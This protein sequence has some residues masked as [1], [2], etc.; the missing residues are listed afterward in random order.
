LNKS[1]LILLI[2]LSQILCAQISPG[3]LTKAHAKLEGISNCTNCHEIGQRVKNSKCLNCHTEVNELISQSKGYHSNSEVTTKNCADC[4]S[5]HHGRNFRIVNFIP[6]NFEHKKTTFPLTGKHIQLKCS[7]CHN[8]KNIVMPQAIKMNSNWMGLSSDCS[9]CHIDYHQGTLGGSCAGCH[10]TTNFRPSEFDHNKAAFVL[11][12][13]HLKTPCI[14]CHPKVIREGKE[15]QRFSDIKFVSCENC[16]KDVHGGRLGKDCKSCHNTNS[17]RSIK[18]NTFDHSKTGF[19]LLGKHISVNCNSCHKNSL[20]E[21]LKYDRCDNCH[22]DYHA[23]EFRTG[24]TIR[25]CRECHNEMGFSPSLFTIDK[26]QKTDYPLAGSHLAVPCAGCHQTNDKWKFRNIGNDCIDCHTNVHRDELSEKYLAGEGCR[27]CHSVN[28]W[29][30]VN[31][32]HLKTDF[33]LEGKHAALDCR[34][35]H[36]PDESISKQR[37]ASLNNYCTECHTDVHAKQFGSGPQEECKRCHTFENWKPERFDHNLTRF[38]LE[39]AH[40]KLKCSECHKQSTK[41]NTTFI[42]YKLE[43]FR[44]AACHS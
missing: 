19:P 11:T 4:H 41:G 18:Q 40:S 12:G 32:N 24:S 9:S 5:E 14:S 10:N 8:K 43:D 35:C 22:N 23:G 25:D 31:F 21:R 26:H 15:F 38:S 28:R 3:D 44:C 42:Q 27:N 20:S 36:L 29:R 2:L 7:D 39:G 13:A 17:F 6:E 30:D 33:P 34:K 1:L 16:H 37:F